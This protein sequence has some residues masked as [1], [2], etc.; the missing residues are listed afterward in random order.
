MIYGTSLIG[1]YVFMH[2][3]SLI[4]GGLPEEVELIP[5]IKSGE[6]VKLNSSKFTVYIVV[7]V[8][9]FAVAALAQSKAYD[10]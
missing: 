5:R 10:S 1:A 4:F 2:G 6:K 9:I 3:W 8:I 7:F